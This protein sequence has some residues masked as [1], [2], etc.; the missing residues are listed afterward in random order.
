MKQEHYLLATAVILAVI[1]RTHLARIILG[2]SVSIA[3]WDVPIWF[4]WV[5]MI[6]TVVLAF[7][8]YKITTRP[9]ARRRL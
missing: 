3:G 6:V 9:P 2:W 5:A 1:A 4:S 7:Y 8:G